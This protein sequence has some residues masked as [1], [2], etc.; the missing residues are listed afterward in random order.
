[1]NDHK[2]WKIM[3]LSV[4][5]IL[6]ASTGAGAFLAGA[7]GN[8]RNENKS[9]RTRG[10]RGENI[11]VDAENGNDTSGNGSILKPYK[12]IQKG[13]D[14]A[15][16]G[17]T[18]SVNPGTYTENVV[19]GKRLT[20]RSTFMSPGNTSVKAAS[21]DVVV[22]RITAD[23]VNLSGF[24]ISG[25]TY[26][27]NSAAVDISSA[28]NCTI[29]G[30]DITDSWYCIDMESCTDCTISGNNLSNN[31]RAG[32]VL[33]GSD[34]NTIRDNIVDS[35]MEYGIYM[36]ED[37]NDNTIENNSVSNCKRGIKIYRNSDR[38]IIAGNTVSSGDYNGIEVNYN[39]DDNNITG[40]TVTGNQIGIYTTQLCEGNR[41]D[42]NT[43]RDN[44]RGIAITGCEDFTLRDNNMTGN[45][46]DFGI[47]GSGE[48]DYRHDIDP[49][50]TVD[51]GP[52]YYWID[53]QDSAVPADAGCFAAIA[54]DNITVRDI[55]VD[56]N[57]D[58]IL[59][60]YTHNS[61]IIN[62]TAADCL[63]GI[64][65]VRS[66]N[67]EIRQCTVSGCW[68]HNILGGRGIYLDD[69]TDS[70]I[71][72][73][74]VSGCEL[75]GID[76]DGRSTGNRITGCTAE[77]N[78]G[79][80]IGVGANCDDCIVENNTATGNKHGIY[81]GRAD[82]AVLR[83]NTADDNTHDGIHVFSSER[84]RLDNNTV[85][86]N[87]GI[88][89]SLHTSTG[90]AVE[91]NSMSG[92][93]ADFDIDGNKPEHFVHDIA[94]TNT[95]EGGKI[96]YW[97]G[98]DGGVISG[99]DAAYV[100][101][102][103]ST[104]ITV[105]NIKITNQGA[106]ILF[107]YTNNSR[108]ENV[109]VTNNGIGIS[110]EY[111]HNNIIVNNTA[112]SNNDH[113]ISL[114]SSDD[115]L[116][117]NNTANSNGENGINLEQ[118]NDRNVV[119]GNT[120]NS[121]GENGISAMF[122]SEHNILENNTLE[123]NTENGIYF[124]YAHYNAIENNTVENNKHGIHLYYGCK[125][126]DIHNNTITGNE[127]YGIYMHDE[128]AGNVI[129]GNQITDNGY[130]LYSDH[131]TEP[132]V[133]D[134]NTDNLIYN[135]YFSNGKDRNAWDNG[136]NR[137][138]ITKTNGT[139]IL[140]SDYLGGNF[141]SDY[142]GADNDGDGLGDTNTPYNSSGGIVS[143]GDGL[144]L[145]FRGPRLEIT[146]ISSREK[147]LPGEEI[148]YTVNVTNTGNDNATNVT[149]VENYGSHSIF[150]NADPAPD[151]GNNTWNLSTLHTNETRTINIT[152][153]AND[154]LS[155]G[156]VIENYVE[157]SCDEGA[158]DSCTAYTTVSAPLLVVVKTDESDSNNVKPGGTI[159]YTIDIMNSGSKAATN[160]RLVEHY[161]ANTTFASADPYPS[162]SDNVWLLGTLA[163]STSTAIHLTV[164]VKEG[165]PNG[166][167]ILNT[168]NVSCDEGVESLD[169]E[170]TTVIVE[171]EPPVNRIINITIEEIEE[172][173]KPG[174]EIN[175]TGM[176][177]VEPDGEVQ[178]IMVWLDG[179][180]VATATLDGGS[181]SAAFSLPQGLSEG[182]HTIT[183]N[184][185]LETGESA[186]KSTEI[187]YTKEEP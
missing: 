47:S 57:T 149:V 34:G 173:I 61:R 13:I 8:E 6:I 142:S 143:G 84:T 158:S 166:T 155:D 69:S 72:D 67:N 125:N 176:V 105:K 89:I 170:Y 97:S 76:L 74:T 4:F 58:G 7:E 130:G 86:N 21:S 26:H 80:G 180:E 60:A 160:L 83:N 132:Y 140:G 96:Y 1:M 138:N 148:V 169:G 10:G 107:A 30:N 186:E 87:G 56:H 38:N 152:V 78:E 52:V 108:I 14:E 16:D 68:H 54:C 111:S 185:T 99:N 145:V 36:S 46:Y 157:V 141:W 134:P 81:L 121:N 90:A 15:A 3:T 32:V 181:Y 144:P 2:L 91:N 35:C 123:S 156:A 162:E 82:D 106:G 159:N 92:N 113:G 183:V 93:G 64:R 109:T 95:V 178:E 139:N 19:V 20:I 5:L 147:V 98:R 62:V 65:I 167:H 43:V 77:D 116:I 174:N 112:S 28:E 137:W 135:N 136:S 55:Q 49:T 24:S 168:V 29:S 22:F 37:C 53:R 39:S 163:A 172:E 153:R 179:T 23:W 120:A 114:F 133:N 17:D 184:V 71:A 101:V 182:N 12:T 187:N 75:M 79:F 88:G 115:N 100:V 70:V 128:N 164:L 171:E 51:G 151:H 11:Y 117:M 131:K 50:N 41:I 45:D 85:K 126:N 118:G 175:V 42:N 154:T 73:S 104:N 146:K 177:T 165:L 59:F 110:L 129:R 161:D 33:S 66:D 44:E 150:I 63:Y 9:E 94:D 103:N 40:N 124:Q 18:I 48:A 25:T 102:Y 122:S 127:N 27:N 119:T 31:D